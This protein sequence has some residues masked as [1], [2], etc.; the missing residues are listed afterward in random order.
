MEW[1]GLERT[2]KIIKLWRGWIGRILKD[3]RTVE[4]L[5]WKDLKDHR[6]VGWLGWKG[7]QRCSP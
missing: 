6:T 4:W 5:G 1:L 3:H 2:L 7:P